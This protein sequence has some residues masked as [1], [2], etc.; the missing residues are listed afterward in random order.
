M[1]RP[2][3]IYTRSGDGG[4]TSLA[5]GRRVTKCHPR[6]AACGEVDELG[7]ALGVAR[8]AG[9][10]A[11]V[12][13]LLATVQHELFDLGAD[14]S[15]PL[16][17]AEGEGART[18]LRLD[19]DYT[20]RLEAAIDRVSSTLPPLNGFVLASGTPAAAAL[21]L[22]RSVCRRA[23]RR[24]VI[25]LAEGE[26]NPEVVRYLNRLSDLLFVLARQAAGG[27]EER[28]VPGPTGQGE[29]PSR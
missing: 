11:P 2:N 7:A 22:A 16:V 23:E 13:R 10:P 25:V 20:R 24:A 28:W 27:A 1:V 12:D 5:D 15:R 17:P 14:L 9:L 18:P 6:I 3:R 19:G 4:D 8:A 21:H 26:A 29:V